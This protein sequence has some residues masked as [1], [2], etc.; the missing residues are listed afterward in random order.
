MTKNWHDPRVPAPDVC[1]L[2]PVLEKYAAS[3]PDKVFAR[4][5]DGSEWTYAQTLEIT[6]RTAA[7]LQALGVRQG[8]NVHVWLPNGP[9]AIR[10]WFATQLPRRGLRADQPG[11]PR[12]HPRACDPAVGRAADRRA[13]GADRAAGRHRPV[14]SSTDIVELAGEGP[15]CPA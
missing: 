7:G 6:R 12:P 2:R 9:D 1:V 4:F 14:R 8:E 10:V 5:A 11:L 13:C 15:R 3:Q